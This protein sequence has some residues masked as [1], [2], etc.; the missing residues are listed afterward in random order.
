[1]L[2]LDDRRRGADDDIGGLAILQPFLHARDG[3]EGGVD[4]V[5]TFAGEGGPKSGDDIFHCSGGEDFQMHGKHSGW[6]KRNAQDIIF[7][8][9][10]RHRSPTYAAS[11]FQNNQ[12]QKHPPADHEDTIPIS[13]GWQRARARARANRFPHTTFQVETITHT[14]VYIS[15]L[16]RRPDPIHDHISNIIVSRPG[17]S[18]PAAGGPP[19]LRHDPDRVAYPARP[20]RPWQPSQTS[21]V[22]GCLDEAAT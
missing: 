20:S 22:W 14:S 13:H 10:G 9:V 4:L 16:A 12:P 6:M 15:D 21:S 19:A 1:M 11:A 3:A 5:A 8:T 18:R 17:S 7:P 2:H